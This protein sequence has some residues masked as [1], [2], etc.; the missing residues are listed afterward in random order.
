M[1]HLNYNGEYTDAPIFAECR[2]I[3][4]NGDRHFVHVII[5]DKMAPYVKESQLSQFFPGL[6]KYGDESIITL[7][8]KTIRPSTVPYTSSNHINMSDV[9]GQWEDMENEIGTALIA[10]GSD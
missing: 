9:Y 4:T 6:Q 7:D 1:M 5:S 10:D 3:Y 8:H 2:Q